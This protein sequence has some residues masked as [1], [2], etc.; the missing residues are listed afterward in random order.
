MINRGILCQF[1]F[2]F[3]FRIISHIKEFGVPTCGAGF[4]ALVRSWASASRSGSTPVAA[5]GIEVED[6]PD[7]IL[8]VSE[9]SPG[10]APFRVAFGLPLDFRGEL[11][12]PFVP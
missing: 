6:E 10:T 2:E 9:L 3:G 5:L 7:L 1:Q 11:P 8:P 4:R 12:W